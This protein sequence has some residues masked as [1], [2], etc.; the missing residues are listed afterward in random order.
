MKL[1]QKNLLE[2]TVF[3]VSLLLVVG[4][5]SYLAYDAAVLGDA[6]PTM[7]VRLGSPERRG[8]HFV[9]PIAVT[10]QGDQTAEDVLVEVVLAGVGA[11][12]RSALEIAFLPRG[13]THEGWAAFRLD[14][15]D[16]ELTGR[17]VGYTQP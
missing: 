15:R 7:V 10:N 13:A 14:P 4:T 16:G 9:V 8:E 3:V 5:L 11:E 12:Q 6:P 1:P 2:W 17:V